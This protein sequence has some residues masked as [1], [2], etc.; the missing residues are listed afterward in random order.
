MDV[1]LNDYDIDGDPFI[2]ESVTDP[3]N[4]TVANQGDYIIYTPN[5]DYC[6]EDD[7]SY[8]IN[9]SNGG[10]SSANVYIII[11]PSTL[12]PYKPDPPKGPA[13]GKCGETYTYSAVTTDPDGD[14]ISYLFDWGDGTTSG[15]TEFV[16]SGTNIS[17]S[18]SWDKG[19]YSIRVKAKDETGMESEWSDPLEVPIIRNKV[20]FNFWIFRVLS[21][22]K[23]FENFLLYFLKI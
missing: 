14:D 22:F 9:D 20:A 18:H 4:G 3:L 11:Y 13:C 6:G 15:W 19:T 17:A 12:P 16:P 7:F 10:I 1:L 5:P 8:T 23:L 21:N 2:I